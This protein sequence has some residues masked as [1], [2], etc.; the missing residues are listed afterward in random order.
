MLAKLAVAGL[1]TRIKDY[2]VLFSGLVISSA[3]FYMFA[4]LAV[5][6]EMIHKSN[7]LISFSAILFN[8]GIILL[9]MITFVYILYANNFLLGMRQKDYGL[10]MML[11][12]KKQRVGFLI[13]CE[14]ML[15]G[16]LSTVL[17]ILFGGV[18][19]IGVRH[20]L[21]KMMG[22]E[23]TYY[24]PFYL[25]AMVI[26]L[27]IYLAVF[28]FAAL[29]NTAVM[30]RKPALD[31]LRRGVKPHKSIRQPWLL[32][33]EV[34]LGIGILGYAYYL[35]RH[36]VLFGQWTLLWCFVITAVG[37]YFVINGTVVAVVNLVRKTS[38]A[39]KQLNTFTLGQLQF[40]IQDYT[41]ILTM[42]SLMFGLA[43][44]ALTMGV[45]FKNQTE[46]TAE[47]SSAYGMVVYN[48][49]IRQ[50]AAMKKVTT[51]KQQRYTYKQVGTKYYYDSSEF[52]RQP[53]VAIQ[54][55]AGS[56]NM[57]TNY[58]YIKYD[59]KKMQEHS[60]E[61]TFYTEMT[62]SAFVVSHK[63]FQQV[64]A[65]A[66]MA[67]FIQTAPIGKTYSQIKQVADAS[68]DPHQVTAGIGGQYRGY[69]TAQSL[70][71]VMEFMGGFLAI[72]FLAM[73]ASCL[74]FKILS[75]SYDDTRRYQMLAK[76]GAPRELLK[77][78]IVKEVA[79]LFFL[80][81]VLGTLDVL[82]GLQM[83]KLLVVAPYRSFGM[84][85]VIFIVLYLGYYALA[86]WMYRR[87][88]LRDIIQ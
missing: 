59:G 72:A 61:L 84:P 35:M 73:L 3:I 43:L 29:I 16:L 88:V 81:A 63:Q 40:R 70:Y 65:P 12:A 80:P 33:V 60:Y 49:N 50:K 45:A 8:I 17:G 75:G 77:R 52:D 62:S 79:V 21:E 71:S 19:S 58:K 20:I 46:Q 39:Q 83:F 23:I 11:G 41:A 66:K 47:V 42:V 2:M 87:I 51:K 67:Y 18:L 31:L 64:Q 69:V 4:T 44:G 13:A 85:F 28:G 36:P 38:W 14:T 78:A 55:L 9:A 5:N 24:R 86:V 27:V 68:S 76:I 1:R 37:S 10:F 32:M 7:D 25:R 26:T 56:E 48:P 74:M 22:M 54:P 53:Y 6:K 34:I 30:V 57:T 15:I 82:F